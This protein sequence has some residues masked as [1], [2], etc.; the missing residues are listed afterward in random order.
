MAKKRK[1]LQKIVWLVVA[2]M[3]AVTMV[4]LTFTSPY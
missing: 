3:V 2:I 1:K 4:L